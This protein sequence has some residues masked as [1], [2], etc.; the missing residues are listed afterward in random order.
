MTTKQFIQNLENTFKGC[1]DIAKTKN[2]DYANSNNP[3]KNFEMSLQV[4][5]NPDRAI[6]V[7]L[8]D[9]ISRI[10]NLLNREGKIKEERLEDT[11][12]DAI[13]YLA[14]LKAYKSK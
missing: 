10:S 6:L 5:V 7:R 11:I 3:F 2:I 12:D 4:G 8:S 1:L 14:I 13:N 9:K